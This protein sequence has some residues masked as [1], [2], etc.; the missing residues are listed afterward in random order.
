MKKRLLLIVP[1]LMQG[2]FERVCVESARIMRDDFEVFLMIFDS[3]N[4][5][6]DVEGINLINIDLPA[7][8]GKIGKILNLLRRIIKIKSIKR[9]YSIDIS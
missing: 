7:V 5:H 9:K 2:G 6:Y 4:A 1:S 3:N 8:P